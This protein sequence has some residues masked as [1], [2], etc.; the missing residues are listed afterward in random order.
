MVALKHRTQVAGTNDPR[1]QVSVTAWNQ[2]HDLT[3]A[4][5]TVLTFD[6]DG[7]AVETPIDELGGASD[8]LGALAVLDT[9]SNANW[10]GADLEIANGGTGASSA[11][12]ARE[13]L[14]ITDGGGKIVTSLLP[15]LA[16]TDIFEVA[17]QAAMLALSS[18]EVG[19]IAIRSD[20]NKTFVLA[21]AGYATLANW[22]ELKTPTDT[23]LAVAGLTGTI[24]KAAL[25]AAL[26]LE[27]G[28]DVQ[29]YDADLAALAALSGDSKLLFRNSSGVWQVRGLG[30]GLTDDGT[31]IVGGSSSVAA[32]PGEPSGS[33][34]G[35]SIAMDTIASAATAAASTVSYLPVQV[36]ASVTVDRLYTYVAGNSGSS[37]EARLAIYSNVG[38]KPAALLHQ[39]SSTVAV[40]TTGSKF[41]TFTSSPTLAAGWYWLAIQTDANPPTVQAV[42]SEQPAMRG[43]LGDGGGATVASAAPIG[44]KQSQ[45]FA[46]GLPAT[47]ASL[48]L[49]YGGAGVP[50]VTYRVA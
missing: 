14:G 28:T 35:A 3:G 22:K 42:A 38:G 46:S 18:A 37:S 16:L 31:N 12:A 30:A 44:Y 10:S 2:D 7:N 26:D 29:A 27:I 41:G 24:T 1:K 19:D 32:R 48:S 50:L 36:T 11:P 33:T 25:L 40:A 5:N 17:S 21:A 8:E 39:C 47:A 6:A 15:G 45:T 13:A 34:F 9:V 20:I 4:P 49:L 23:V 43:I